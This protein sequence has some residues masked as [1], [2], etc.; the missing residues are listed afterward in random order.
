MKVPKFCPYSLGINRDADNN[1]YNAKFPCVGPVF[2]GNKR[3]SFV[4]RAQP[5]ITKIKQPIYHIINP[6]KATYFSE[7]HN[8][9]SSTKFSSVN[10]RTS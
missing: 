7:K 6:M 2:I 4:K 5:A 9:I 3:Y 10:S 8:R 1:L